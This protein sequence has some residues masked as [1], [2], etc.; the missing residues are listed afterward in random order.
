MV[1]GQEED[2]HWIVLRQAMSYG[3]EDQG[4]ELILANDK[5]PFSLSCLFMQKLDVEFSESSFEQ[6]NLPGPINGRF[7]FSSTP[8][9][10]LYAMKKKNNIIPVMRPG[11]YQIKKC[12]LVG[13]QNSSGSAQELPYT[14]RGKT[15]VGKVA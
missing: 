3:R 8:P 5:K 1:Y 2:R 6:I 7:Q 4:D 15:M 13:L 9:V 10:F 14:F 11:A 12:R